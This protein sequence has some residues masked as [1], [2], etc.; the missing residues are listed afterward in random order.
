MDLAAVDVHQ[1]VFTR[2]DVYLIFNKVR[3]GVKRIH[4]AWA[5][6]LLVLTLMG[7]P[8]PLCVGRVTS[9]DSHAFFV[10]AQSKFKQR[11]TG[12]VF[13]RITI[14]RMASLPDVI[15]HYTSLSA[16][17]NIIDGIKEG[18]RFLTFWASDVRTMNDPTEMKYGLEQAKKFIENWE[19][20]HNVPQE[21]RLSS[22]FDSFKDQDIC[23]NLYAI[24]FSKEPNHLA[25][26]NGY[27][28]NRKGIVI[29]IKDAGVDF[30]PSDD[31][32]PVLGINFVDVIYGG[33]QEGSCLFHDMERDYT[34]YL[35]KLH[36]GKERDVAG[37][38]VTS[39]Y[40]ILVGAI[41]LVK[42][43]VYSYEKE[44]RIVAVSSKPMDYR[45]R[46]GWVIPYVKVRIPF[47]WV[48]SLTFGPMVSDIQVSL[49]KQWLKEKG[50]DVPTSK[51]DIPYREV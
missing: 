11:P 24:S 48:E 21:E 20:A 16:F 41:C 15:Y 17:Q 7:I 23:P 14:P 10:Y 42:H 30:S 26:W 40:N 9:A 50:L 13:D 29:G 1:C 43:E 19:N 51:A 49:W 46:N 36:G 37:L 28:D 35:E 47:S 3:V 5:L 6:V 44:T 25:M 12:D 4:T 32:A 34:R 39:L 45:K 38:Q 33:I 27:A 22:L 18:D 2:S 31:E 8:E